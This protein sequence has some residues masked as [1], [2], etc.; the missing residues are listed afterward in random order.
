MF[1]YHR[2]DGVESDLAGLF[3]KPLVSVVVLGRADRKVEPVWMSSPVLLAGDDHG[4]YTLGIVR[5]DAAAVK[6][7]ASVDCV[8]LISASVPEYLNAMS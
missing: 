7:S 4:L 6:T 2:R 8:N 3:C 1:A 5:T